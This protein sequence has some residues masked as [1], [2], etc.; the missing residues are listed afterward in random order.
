MGF[1]PTCV[2]L[3]FTWFVAKGDTTAYV[4][5][6]GFEPPTFGSVDRRSSPAELQTRRGDRVRTCNRRGFGDRRSPIELH[7][8]V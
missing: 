2:Q 6:E 1:E 4:R 8:Y 3:P 7:P 5:L